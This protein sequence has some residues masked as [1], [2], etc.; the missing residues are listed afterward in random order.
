VY[1][2]K[3][4][5][6]QIPGIKSPQPKFG[7]T[8]NEQSGTFNRTGMNYKLLNAAEISKGLRVDYDPVAGRPR[9][10]TYKQYSQQKP[11][12]DRIAQQTERNFT[13]D[14]TTEGAQSTNAAYR[15]SGF[16]RGHLAPR[17]AFAAADDVDLNPD[18]PNR[19]KVT[20]DQFNHPELAA[21]QFTNVVPMKHELNQ[22]SE[23]R[24]SERGTIEKA[25][26]FGY[27]DVEI[28]PIYDE[29]PPRLRDG[30][31]VPK[32]VRRTIIGPDGTVLESN[33]YLNE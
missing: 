30:T 25:N 24:A 7:S 11:G 29:N 4:P 17:E 32:A 5:L 9:K 8:S 31:P 18:L 13:K 26:K 15:K 22:G 28:V 6:D 3:K 14:P 21:D 27:V 23:W 16:E 19:L 33:T 12:A 10:I 1:T 2:G 20:S